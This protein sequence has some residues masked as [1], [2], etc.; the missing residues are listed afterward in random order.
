M[1]EILYEVGNIGF[2]GT[3]LFVD[4]GCIWSMIRAKKIHTFRMGIIKAISDLTQ[5][6]IKA[7]LF[8]DFLW[9]YEEFETVP[10]ENMMWPLWKPLKAE[11]YWK[12]LSFLTSA[13]NKEV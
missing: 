2:F 8:E 9:R 5:E 1:K 4:I 7:G 6:D 12:D 13:I 10:F 11:Q 3:L